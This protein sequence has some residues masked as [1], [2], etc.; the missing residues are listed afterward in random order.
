MLFDK[1]KLMVKYKVEPDDVNILIDDKPVI[2]TLNE[3]ERQAATA[4]DIII[5]QE[6]DLNHHDFE[7]A[8][9]VIYWKAGEDKNAVFIMGIAWMSASNVQLFEGRILAPGIN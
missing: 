3:I 2:D 5:N 6:Y 9:R 1:L 4:A 8:E 7:R